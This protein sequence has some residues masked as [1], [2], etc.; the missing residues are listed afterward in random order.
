MSR[1]QSAVVRGAALRGLEGIAPRMKQSRRHYGVGLSMPFREGTD[2]EEN[3]YFD[4]FHNQKYCR[5]RVKWLI[6]KVY[7]SPIIPGNEIVTNKDQGDKILTDT[8]RKTGVVTKYT[9]DEAA[10]SSLPLYST[11]LNDPPDYYTDSSM[12]HYSY[13]RT[14]ILVIFK[15]RS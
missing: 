9:P 14:S 7:K 8:S 12:L 13:L 6:S 15:V 2:P 5:C 1:R 4:D 3:S 10:S 11:A